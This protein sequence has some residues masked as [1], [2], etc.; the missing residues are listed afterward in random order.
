[1]LA[2]PPT[3]PRAGSD[4]TVL[5]QVALVSISAQGMYAS[6]GSTANHCHFQY[7]A[8][9]TPTVTFMS[10][11]GAAGKTGGVQISGQLVGRGAS[12]V[13]TPY[14]CYRA[15]IYNVVIIARAH[16]L[17]CWRNTRTRTLSPSIIITQ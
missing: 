3:A 12:V 2:I 1:M 17:F 14:A 11:G 6:C 9:Q 4:S 8:A 5:V 13:R 16:P 7:R 10:L 15:N